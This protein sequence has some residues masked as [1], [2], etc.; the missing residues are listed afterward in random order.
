MSHATCT[1]FHVLRDQLH[2]VAKCQRIKPETTKV[3]KKRSHFA[4]ATRQKLTLIRLISI[5]RFHHK[6]LQAGHNW[7]IRSNI[8]KVVNQSQH[9]T[10][11]KRGKTCN[12]SQARENMLVPNTG[13]RGTGTKRGKTYVGYHMQKNARKKSYKRPLEPR[14]T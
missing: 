2:R 5:L 11:A 8:N 10:R 9:A 4:D 12:R 7:P 14:Y 6:P 13:K 1:I 3:T